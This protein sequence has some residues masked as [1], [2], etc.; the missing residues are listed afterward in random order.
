MQANV[1]L[2]NGE[3]YSGKYVAL[4]SFRDKD[5]ISSGSNPL[6]VYNDAKS[7]G[8]VDPVVFYVPE[9]NTVHIY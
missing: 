5:A 7:K 1:L 2:N 9:K 6:D 3:R 4:K 8:A